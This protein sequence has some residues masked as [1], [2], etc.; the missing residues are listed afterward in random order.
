MNIA[1]NTA[2]ANYLPFICQIRI[3][4]GNVLKESNFF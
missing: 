1:N 3:I 2:G 4:N